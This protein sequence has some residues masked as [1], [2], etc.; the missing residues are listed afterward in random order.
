MELNDKLTV[1]IR[2]QLTHR[3]D[4]LVATL[5]ERGKIHKVVSQPRKRRRNSFD[6]GDLK[7][8]TEIRLPF[9]TY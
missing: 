4:F 6:F 1:R 2:T 5:R 7:S 8:R 9:F 3:L